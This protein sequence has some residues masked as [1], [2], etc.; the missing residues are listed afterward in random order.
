VSHSMR[1]SRP[2]AITVEEFEL[3]RE[4][5]RE[6]EEKSAEAKD[7]G[8]QPRRPGGWKEDDLPK[9]ED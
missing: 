1:S 6:F 7:C 8:T 9:G 3:H 2:G 4:L 5:V